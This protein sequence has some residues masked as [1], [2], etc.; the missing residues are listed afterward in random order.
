MAH[1]AFV[2]NLCNDVIRT[3]FPRGQPVLSTLDRDSTQSVIRRFSR[4][5]PSFSTL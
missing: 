3:G 5:W 2:A 4:L 1:A